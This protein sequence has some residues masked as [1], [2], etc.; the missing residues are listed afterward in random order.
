MTIPSY[1]PKGD[2][3]VLFGS[4]LPQ[5]GTISTNSPV[6]ISQFIS[7]TVLWASFIKT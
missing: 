7:A 2:G 5:N 3:K 4:C 6:G 1:Q